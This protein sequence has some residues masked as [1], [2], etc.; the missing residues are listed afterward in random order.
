MEACTQ[1][2]EPGWPREPGWA[3]HCGRVVVGRPFMVCKARWMAPKHS[4]LKSLPESDKELRQMKEILCLAH[5][6]N[7]ME[8]VLKRFPLRKALR[9]LGGHI[10][11]QYTSSCTRS[12]RVVHCYRK[13][14]SN[15][16]PCG[17]CAP[18]HKPAN[19]L[20]LKKRKSVL[21][22]SK[23][24]ECGYVMDEFRGNTQSISQMWPS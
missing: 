20:T 11:A 15:R 10:C 24:R 17:L 8:I 19:I 22:W 13:R 18:R 3:S 16:K 12:A 7:L 1:C 4:V 6:N 14:W 5:K 2:W 21:D 9:V 23:E